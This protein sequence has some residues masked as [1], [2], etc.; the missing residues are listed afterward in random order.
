MSVSFAA[1]PARLPLG[2]CIT[3]GGAPNRFHLYC[4]LLAHGKERMQPRAT[5]LQ[6][7]LLVFSTKSKK[8]TN[9]TRMRS[10]REPGSLTHPQV[11]PIEGGGASS[12]V[13]TFSRKR[14]PLG[15]VA[16]VFNRW[17]C[18]LVTFFPRL[19]ATLLVGEGH[20]INRG[21]SG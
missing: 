2:G 14:T 20:Y 18:P 17:I 6:W 21:Y 19:Q 8:P 11:T 13:E 9:P 10:V 1:K 16:A 12:H 7:G 15:I 4:V 5:A 3:W